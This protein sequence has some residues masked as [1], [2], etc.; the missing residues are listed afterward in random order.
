MGVNSSTLQSWG[1]S[2]LLAR[3]KRRCRRVS[4]P[5][6]SASAR[7]R[8]KRTSD[9]RILN[10]EYDDF[11]LLFFYTFKPTKTC[12]VFGLYYRLKDTDVLVC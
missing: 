12:K 8:C 2:V 5:R 6:L 10:R 11:H 9:L 3:N 4:T 7:S 1:G